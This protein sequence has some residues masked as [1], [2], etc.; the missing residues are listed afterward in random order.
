MLI[1][2]FQIGGKRYVFDRNLSVNCHER[3]GNII[4]AA[5]RTGPR[6]RYSAVF[7]CFPAFRSVRTDW[8]KNIFNRAKSRTYI[9]SLRCS[10][11]AYP[12]VPVKRLTFLFSFICLLKW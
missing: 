11:S 6:I 10:P 4:K 2:S 3:A 9:K 5:T 7:S 12:P 1:S 8:A